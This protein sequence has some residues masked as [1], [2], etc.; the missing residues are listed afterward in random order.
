MNPIDVMQQQPSLQVNLILIAATYLD[1]CNEHPVSQPFEFLWLFA[2]IF[3]FN[4]FPQKIAPHCEQ[5]QLEADQKCTARHKSQ[6]ELPL[7]LIKRGRGQDLPKIVSPEGYQKFCQK[8]GITLKRGDHIEMGGLPLFLLYSLQSQPCN[9]L[10]L[11]F[12]VL[13][14]CIYH[15]YI[16][17]SF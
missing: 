10:I 11:V 4:N 7:P 6:L 5:C 8:E 16:S 13:K 2:A 14:H 9:I 15:F 17:D 12:I 1:Q 3:D